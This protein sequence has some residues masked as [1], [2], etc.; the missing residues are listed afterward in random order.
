MS[1]TQKPDNTI[2]TLVLPPAETEAQ[3]TVTVKQGDLGH[4]NTFDYAEFGDLCRALNSALAAFAR[5]QADPPKDIQP[6]KTSSKKKTKKKKAD[7]PKPAGK[8]PYHLLDASGKRRKITMIDPFDLQE[9]YQ[10]DNAK[11]SFD[12]LEEAVEVA[13]HLV[14]TVDKQITVVFANGK[15]VKVLPEAET[16]ENKADTDDAEQAPDTTDNTEVAI[17]EDVQPAD[18]DDEPVTSA[19]DSDEDDAPIDR[20]AVNADETEPAES[21]EEDDADTAGE[22]IEN[23]EDRDDPD[24]DTESVPVGESDTEATDEPSYPDGIDS[25]A[26]RAFYD[27]LKDETLTL[28]IFEDIQTLRQHG[29]KDNVIKQRQV[30]GLI[31]AYLEDQADLIEQVFQIAHT[32]TEFD[33]VTKAVD[34]A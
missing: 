13:E 32:A 9:K 26:K 10:G 23:D 11:L 30:K 1:K 18:Q 25:D 33:D 16:S 6:A 8:P 24:T 2:I 31:A 22:P 20:V 28:A 29:W 3:A 15:P 27:L 5:V 21:D 14:G 7:K 34:S 19:D 4:L 17:T 12:T